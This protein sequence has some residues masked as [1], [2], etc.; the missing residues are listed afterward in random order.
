MVGVG[1]WR[2]SMNLTSA[3]DLESV[4]VTTTLQSKAERSRRSVAY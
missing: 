3:S 1:T 2:V 4:I